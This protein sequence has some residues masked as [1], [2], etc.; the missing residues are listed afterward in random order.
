METITLN[1]TPSASLTTCHA[2]QYDIGRQ[3]RF[4]LVNG[5]DNFVLSGGETVTLKI[6]R[7]DGVFVENQ[8]PNTSSNYVIWTSVAG[9]CDAAGIS[10]C[11]LSVTDGGD[12]L[13]SA[14]FWMEVEP[15]AYDGDKIRT[16]SVGPDDVCTFETNLPEPLP[17]IKCNIEAVQEG[18]G[19]PYPPGGGKNKFDKSAV[20]HGVLINGSGNY[21]TYPN[22]NVSDY[23]P[24]VEGVGYYLS[25]LTKHPNTNQDNYELFDAGKTKTGFAN[26]KT[27]EYPYVIPAGVKFV[28][29]TVH[30][31]DLNTAMFATSEGEY[32]PYSNV[33]PING[34]SEANIVNTQNESIVDL[35]SIDSDFR[36][37][38]AFNQLIQN[39]N[40]IDTTGWGSANATQTASGNVLSITKTGPTGYGCYRQFL[41]MPLNHKVLRTI[42]I[43]GASGVTY[44]FNTHLPTVVANGSW[45]T[46]ATIKT[47]SNSTIY[48]NVTTSEDGDYQTVQVA[49]LMFIDLTQMFGSTIADYIYS[50]EQ[51]NAGAGVAFFRNIYPEDYYPYDLGTKEIVGKETP[52]A[53]IAFGQ[54][55]YNGNLETT[56]G[57]LTAIKKSIVVDEAAQ[58]S[59]NSGNSWYMNPGNGQRSAT[60]QETVISD[61]FAPGQTPNKYVCFMHPSGFIR[62][63]TEDSFATAA[64]L[65][66]ALGPLTF[67]YPL[68]IPESYQITPTQVRALADQEN[69]V[70]AD[71]GTTELKYLDTEA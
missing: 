68:E 64:D 20:T 25:G 43:K 21:V 47:F 3:V 41:N 4:N 2:S 62:F 58:I 30:D 61:K 55:V 66:S 10:E 42:D 44:Y 57:T 32:E 40:F 33:R 1:M 8:V 69:N 24:V 67:V 52:E 60:A 63:N 5:A 9:E 23:T 37:T 15:D 12:L 70:F 51:N 71:T 14:N 45:Q 6:R 50:L 11:E 46:V 26:V 7:A 65:L 29:Y 22:N 28:R 53:T 54:T 35:F 56:A 31:D 38:V 19:T 59:R 16:V 34:Y 17:Y 18:S 48:F 13:G 49:N 39:G 27:W 36:G